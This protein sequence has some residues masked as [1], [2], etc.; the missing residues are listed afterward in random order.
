MSKLYFFRHAQASYGAAN[1][2][3]LSSKGEQQAAE[4][5]KYLVANNY[6]FDKIFTGPLRRQK[7]TFEIV[8]AIYQQNNLSL[9]E[10]IELVDLKEHA[11]PDILKKMIPELVV[12]VPQ[13]EKWV[14]EMN[15]NPALKRK[16][17]LLMYEYFMYEWVGGKLNSDGMESWEE[18]MAAVQNGLNRILSQTEKGETIGSFT[19]GGT[20]SALTAQTL[21]MEDSKKIT[22]LSFAIR[23][24]SF[25]SYLS[26]QKQFNLLTFNELPHLAGEMV[27]F[28]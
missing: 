14:V 4:L 5:G 17:S 9:P 13:V 12:T 25:S 15:E 22:A 2:D 1:Y 21:N 11:G 24:T 28:V 19:S 3:Q 16:N 10:P 18:F 6:Q 23:N 20:I 26:S 7:H 27:T 8:N